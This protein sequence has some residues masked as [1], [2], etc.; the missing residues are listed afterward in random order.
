M[1]TRYGAYPLRGAQHNI[2][3]HTA[4]KRVPAHYV[5][6]VEKKHM[7]PVAMFFVTLMTVLLVGSAG[8]VVLT[9]PKYLSMHSPEEVSFVSFVEAIPETLV[10]ETPVIEE[11]VVEEP[12]VDTSKYGSQI[13]DPE[14]LQANNIFLKEG[15]KE[16]NVTLGFVGDILLDDE[17]AVLAAM[18]QRGGQMSDGI[19]QV[20]LDE[21]NGVDVM[22]VNNEFPYTERGTR[23]ADKQ[24]TFHADY[25]T[26]SYL[27]DMGA[28]VA[29]VANNHV[30]DFGEQG[31]LDTLDTLNVAGIHPVGAG[32][33][34][35][36]AS[37]PVYYI[38]NDIK[39]AIVAASQIERMS[40]PNTKGATETSPG[41]F[42]CWQSDRI[43]DAVREAKENADYVIAC[44]H[45]GTEKD[46]IP[47]SWQLEM[48]PKLAEAGA[49]LIIGDHTHRLQGVYY[50]GDTP[51]FYSLGNFW[52]NGF[53][54]DTG[55]VEV[56]FDK[57]GISSL[58]FLPAIQQNSKTGLVYGQEKDRIISYLRSL[59]KGAFI[60][61]DGY[62]LK[63]Q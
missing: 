20:T 61:D 52:F 15:S 18:L 59:S 55:M 49:D 56:S 14:Y 38:V 17:Y 53:Q 1:D 60:S 29:I 21:M 30:F 4:T 42:R 62:I 34:I 27:N 25:S 19:S 13:N 23:Q 5:K 37:R 51:C 45:W 58:Q 33:N 47:D 9:L 8:I 10:M 12:P 41:V 16:G 50:Y 35:E 36:E 7:S 24:Y 28:D 54:I 3:R 32:R 31:L 63:A 39:I 44:I 22:V 43:Y 26:V 11:L 57:D 46:P 40:N 48:G 2:R 6:H